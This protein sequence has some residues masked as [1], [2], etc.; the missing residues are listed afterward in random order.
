[1]AFIP[2]PVFSPEYG[3]FVNMIDRSHE[4]TQDYAQLK[5]LIETS[6]LNSG[7]KSLLLHQ[8]ADKFAN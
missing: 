7:E 2:L 3:A 6:S 4:S 1:M 5:H 8:L